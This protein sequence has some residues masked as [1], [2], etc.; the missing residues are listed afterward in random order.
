MIV[1]KITFTRILMTVLIIIDIKTSY[2]FQH[3]KVAIQLIEKALENL[4]T[5]E[6]DISA[7]IQQI[8]DIGGKQKQNTE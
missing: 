8:K 6:G 7:F 3:I 4:L 1:S 2:I 5:T